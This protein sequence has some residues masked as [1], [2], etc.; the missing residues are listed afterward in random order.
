MKN[1]GVKLATLEINHLFQICEIIT[2]SPDWKTA[3]DK[4]MQLLRAI[5]IFDNMVLYKQNPGGEGLDVMYARAI[6][7]GRSG[8]AEISWGE[9]LAN[10]VSRQRKT[11]VEEPGSFSEENR[12]KYPYLLGIPLLVSSHYLGALI[13]IRFGGPPFTPAQIQL[14]EFVARQVTLLIERSRLESDEEALQAQYKQVQL[15][16]EFISTIT[17]E[18]RSPLGFIKGYTT[19]LLRSDTTW[20][21]D[22]R[23]EFLQIIDRETDH[24]QELITNLLDSARLQAGLMEMNFQLLRIDVLL[25]DLVARTR[26]HNPRMPINLQINKPLKPIGGDPL[27]L[28]QVFENLISNCVKYAPG[29]ELLIKI[30]Q[31]K[32]GTMIIFKDFGPGI[33]PEHLP[34]LFERF[35]R[36]P[37]QVMNSKGS[38][39]GLFIC[40]QIIQAHHGKIVAESDIGEGMVFHIFLPY[41][42]IEN[43]RKEG[44]V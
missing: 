8:E 23:F 21:E 3:L 13:F 42:R 33:A 40:K 19:T 20:D 34:L 7:R 41:D 11:I 14:A 44:P 26:L 28:T 24:M 39:L 1:L 22:S 6:G 27:R 16:Q 29:Y 10:N 9:E 32:A 37:D 30:E 36:G 15:Q 17:H 43:L 25:S 18:L 31:D 5:F 4:T 38:G 35:F 2:K 12:V